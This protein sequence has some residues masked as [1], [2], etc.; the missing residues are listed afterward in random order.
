M[1]RPNNHRFPCLEDATNRIH[2][3]MTLFQ[4]TIE[5]D[6]GHALIAEQVIAHAGMSHK[7]ERLRDLQIHGSTMLNPGGKVAHR[8]CCKWA[9]PS[10]CLNQM[11]LG[12]FCQFVTSKLVVLRW[13]PWRQWRAH[14]D[15]QDSV[16]HHGRSYQRC[17]SSRFMSIYVH[18]ISICD[19]TCL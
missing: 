5:A 12:N 14:C 4:V 6:L 9:D 19:F 8:Y 7:A 10:H 1:M 18:M 15:L 11:K 13:P 16:I 2:G 17:S 3:G